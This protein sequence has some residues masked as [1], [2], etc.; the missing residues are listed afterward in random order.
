MQ[1]AVFIVALC[2]KNC[3]AVVKRRQFLLNT[4]L[5]QYV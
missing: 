2:N 3:R 1:I 4:D 5:V